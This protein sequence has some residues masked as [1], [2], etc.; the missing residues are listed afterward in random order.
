MASITAPNYAK[1][2]TVSDG[3]HYGYIH[4]TAQL[5][6]PTLLFLHGYPSSSYHWHN[7]VAQCESAR[8]GMIAPDLL[9]YGD[10]SKPT[11]VSAYDGTVMAKHIIELLDHE[12]LPVVVGIG[13]DWGSIFLSTIARMFP[14]RFDRLVFLAVGYWATQLPFTDIDAVNEEATKMIGRPLFGYWHFFNKPEAAKI[15]ENADVRIYLISS[16]SQI[17]HSIFDCQELQG[18][19]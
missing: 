19:R 15:L 3:T 2:F 17:P 4:V 18:R 16:R 11:E 6:K 7:Q 10:T 1:T 8:Y 5:G 9:G 14:Q 12:K 13:H